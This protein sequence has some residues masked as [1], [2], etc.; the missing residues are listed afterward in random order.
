MNAAFRACAVVP[1]LDNPM[2][3]CSV[4]EGLRRHGLDVV[5]VDDGSAAPGRAACEAL[6][7]AGLVTLRRLEPNRGKGRAVKVGFDVARTLGFSHAFQVDADA[8]HDLERVPA[9]L[10]AARERP[11]ALVLGYPEYGDDAPRAR[12]AGRGIMRFWVALEVADRDA[13]RDAMIGFR[14]YPRDAVQ[15]VG[16][17]GAG[18]EFDSEIAVRL[19]QGGTPTVNLPV[20]V[21]YLSAAE[22]GVSHFRMLRDNLRFSWLHARLCTIGLVRWLAARAPRSAR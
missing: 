14:V 8:Q 21:R 2:T 15:R 22:G 18:M 17:S 7:A 4:V 6:A 10:G 12:L 11:E 1:T 16:R 20:R 3:V 9:F 19:V 13:I 5:L